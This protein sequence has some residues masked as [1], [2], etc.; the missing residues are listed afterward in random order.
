M[1]RAAANSEFVIRKAARILHGGGVIAYPTEGVYGLGCLPLCLEAVERIL[2][3]KQRRMSR[4]LILV[5]ADVEQL[6]P[7]VGTMPKHT[8]GDLERSWPGP[9]TWVVPAAH[10]A[11]AWITGGRDTI[12][13][14][15]SAHPVVGALCRHADSAIVSTSAN[16]SGRSPCRNRMVAM[17]SFGQLVDMIVP[18]ETGGLD[19][20]TE[21]RD[22]RTGQVI[23]P[24]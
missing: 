17:R 9:V 21:I 4:G 23:R 24:G 12:A 1:Q 7:Y 22:A 18:G 6:R 13:V 11:P 10:H 19:R 2:Q 16:R 14:R 3:I 15:V 20:P 8:W 5:A